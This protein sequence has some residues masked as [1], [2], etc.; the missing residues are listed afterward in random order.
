MTATAPSNLAQTAAAKASGS[1][2]AAPEAAPPR[3][4]C[5]SRH[6]GTDPDRR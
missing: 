2:D 4:A 6:L 1:D 3:W 5:P